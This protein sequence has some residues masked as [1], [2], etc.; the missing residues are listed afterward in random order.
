MMIYDY[1]PQIF[2]LSSSWNRVIEH[3]DINCGMDDKTATT[4]MSSE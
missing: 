4:Q 2:I 3:I 1:F